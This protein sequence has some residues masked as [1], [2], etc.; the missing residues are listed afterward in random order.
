[1]KRIIRK[2]D[3]YWKLIDALKKSNASGFHED[4][5]KVIP[6]KIKYKKGLE[7]D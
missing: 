5:K 6:R 1:M 7:D 3:P 2:R 4:K